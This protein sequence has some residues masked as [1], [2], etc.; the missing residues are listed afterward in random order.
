MD[1]WE[2]TTG[3]P[4]NIEAQADL[5]Q[6][7]E[8]PSKSSALEMEIEHLK[9]QVA[10][11]SLE[12]ATGELLRCLR[13]TAPVG[14]TDTDRREWLLVAFDEIKE[15]PL[16]ELAERCSHARK[17]ADLPSKIIPAIFAYKFHPYCGIEGVKL[18]L[19]SR[20]RQFANQD[21]ARIENKPIER[22]VFDTAKIREEMD[23]ASEA[24]APVARRLQ[25]L[26]TPTAEELAE[27]AAQFKREHYS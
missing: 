19:V 11:A 3:Q 14:M 22:E 5:R 13:L 18:N 25:P 4:R 1:T 21:K 8:T 6:S 9:A 15:I 12:A 10:P 27:I 2:E 23:F 7:G 17:V 20:Q 26:H 16:C 24:P